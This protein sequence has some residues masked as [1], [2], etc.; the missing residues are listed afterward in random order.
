MKISN[1]TN[2]QGTN[3]QSS[4][5]VGEVFSSIASFYDLMNDIMSVG[6]HRLWKDRF[7]RG[8]NPG[9]RPGGLPMNILDVAGG[10]GDIAFRMFDHATNI[11]N[12]MET[13]VTCA[14][15]NVD[16][17]HFFYSQMTPHITY[18]HGRDMLHEGE[19]RAKTDTPYGGTQRI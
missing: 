14:D 2:F 4:V 18:R 3:L 19:R 6:I 10:T 11:H 8:L 15:I 16:M 12:D 1:S 9:W 5:S 13:H 7:V 17:L